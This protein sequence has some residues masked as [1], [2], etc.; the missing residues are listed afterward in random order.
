MTAQRTGASAPDGAHAVVGR[1][2]YSPKRSS[3]DIYHALS[4]VLQSMLGHLGS[5][6]PAQQMGAR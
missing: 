3:C 6:G 4:G 5:A 1:A 2:I